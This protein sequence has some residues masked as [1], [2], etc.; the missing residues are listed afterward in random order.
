VVREWLRTQQTTQGVQGELYCDAATGRCG[1]NEQDF[2]KLK[3]AAL[4][5]C[6]EKANR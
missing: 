2:K 3:R 1:I 5:G 4:G 6:A